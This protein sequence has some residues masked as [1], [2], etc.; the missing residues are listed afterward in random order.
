MT[1]RDKVDVNVTPDK[2][3][4]FIHNEKVLFAI[5]KTSLIEMYKKYSGDIATHNDR[6]PVG[7]Y[8]IGVCL[9]ELKLG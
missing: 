1:H 2:R 5:V 3:Q 9:G 8:V 4:V 7:K 6:T